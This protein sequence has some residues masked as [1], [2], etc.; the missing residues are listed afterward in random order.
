[1]NGS[2]NISSKIDLEFSE[3]KIVFAISDCSLKK[4]FSFYNL[5]KSMAKEFVS[6]LKKIEKMTWGQFSGL[7]RKNGLTVE[8]PDSDNFKMIDQENS[9]I[10]QLV[11]KHYF[12]FRVKKDDLFRVFGYQRKQFFYITQIDPGGKKNHP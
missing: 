2:S 12:H 10:D 3:H 7:N 4:K 8:D 11:E 9:S 1:M 6:C 5:N